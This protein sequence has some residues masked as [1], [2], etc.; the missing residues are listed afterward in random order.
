[1]IS[2]HWLVLKLL[3]GLNKERYLLLR[4]AGKRETV[5][6]KIFFATII[7]KVGTQLEPHISRDVFFVGGGVLLFY[8]DLYAA[9]TLVVIG[10]LKVRLSERGWR[11]QEERFRLFWLIVARDFF[12][13]LTACSRASLV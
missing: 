4:S 1:M 13:V 3:L 12:N 5:G 10:G 11:G 6:E 7:E 9:S 2:G 8:F